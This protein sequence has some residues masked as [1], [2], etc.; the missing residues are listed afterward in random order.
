MANTRAG[1]GN[2]PMMRGQVVATVTPFS[3]KGELMLDAFAEVLR[4]HLDCGVGGIFLSGDKGEAWALTPAELRQLTETAVR[5]VAGRVPVF[6]G[7]SAITA[8]DTIALSGIAAEAGADGLGL[9]PQS[10]LLHGTE[11]EI[12]ARFEAVSRAVPL[13]VMVYNSPSRTGLNLPPETLEA[14]CG[15]S[16]VIGVKEASGDFVH[17]SRVIE[18][19]ADRIAVLVGAGH[20]IVPALDLGAVG[21]LSTGPE[22][23]GASAQRIMDLAGKA[24]SA[25]KRQWHA[26]ITEVFN[27]LMDLETRPAAFKA[28]LNMIGVPAGFP[29]EP[30]QPLSPEG[31]A[32]LRDVLSRRGVIEEPSAPRLAS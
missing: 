22:L 25:E 1:G 16:P 31:E 24:S 20:Y 12:V 10:Y 19:F 29:R 6:A 8:R 2:E 5:E 18:R 32:R 15:V 13:P 30:V 23:F 27:L 11:A 7:T 9:Q 28:A 4:W 26:R 14:V 17:V 21:Y 3:A